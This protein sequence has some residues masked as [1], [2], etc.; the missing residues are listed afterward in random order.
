MKHVVKALVLASVAIAAAVDNVMAEVN[1]MSP[2][3]GADYYQVW[4]K[5]HGDW[6][7]IFPQEY[8]GADVYVGTRFH[9]NFGVEL[10]YLWSARQSKNWAL[11]VGTQFFDGT[12]T[13][14]PSL[15][16]NTK[17]RR[18]GG[19]LDVVG[20]LPIAECL[21]FIGSVGFGWVQT[22]ITTS[23]N[24]ISPGHSQNSSALTSVSGKGRGTFRVGIGASYM[25]TD[26]VG[27][28][29]KVGWESTS[30][31]RLK[32]N[33]FFTNLGYDTSGFKGTTALIVGTFVKF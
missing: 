25:L 11:P 17:I 13:D 19:Y 3:L 4:M 22:K 29:A 8:P 33:A 28:R 16:G 5:G 26:M 2:Y 6:K 15:S 31:L 30:N 27:V 20:F 32:G 7:K 24:N 18:T 10:G 9:E 23:F 12:I 14:S 21:E 1:D